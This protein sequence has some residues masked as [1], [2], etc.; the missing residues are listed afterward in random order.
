MR[1]M[2][3]LSELRLSLSERAI[4]FER[5][6]FSVYFTA[7]NLALVREFSGK[8]SLLRS[9][10][11]LTKCNNLLSSFESAFCNCLVEKSMRAVISSV[12]SSAPPFSM[13]LD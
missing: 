9:I 11:L 12:T 6:M 4:T 3:R 1:C 7:D 10:W 8:K 13:N 5:S 2:V